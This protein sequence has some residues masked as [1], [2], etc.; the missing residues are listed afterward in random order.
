MITKNPFPGMN[1][2]F[3][4]RW[5]DAHTM[6]IAYMRDA[7]QERLPDDLVAG[8]EEQVVAIGAD[9]PP[10]PIR[11]DVSVT[12]P[13]E[14]ATEGGV[15]V[16]ARVRAPTSTLPTRIFV[17]DEVERW[18]EI[19]DEAGRLVTVI[20][21][22]S[23]ANKIGEPARERYRNRRAI[24]M[25]GGVNVVEIDL[26]RQGASAFPD[27]MRALARAKGAPYGVCVFLA[28]ALQEREAYIIGLRQPLP[29]ISVPLRPTDA[30]V[31]LELQ[32]LIDQCHERGRYHLLRYG[33]VLD[34]PLTPDDAAWVDQILR[35]H[36]L[37]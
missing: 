11:P 15:A 2:F 34:P 8:A 31:A 29:V 4:Q 12:N 37:R 28:A 16:A 33:A 20:E 23:P 17:D 32:P 1:P 14:A 21:L 3:E 6:L 10:Q 13:W 30:D 26:V 27:E 18:I 35:H 9:G 24:L 36:Q 19:H 25:R 7:L 5:Q 22:L